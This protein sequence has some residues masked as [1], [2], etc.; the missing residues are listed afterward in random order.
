MKKL[1]GFILILTVVGS[2]FIGCKKTE[3]KTET[4][5]TEPKT[6]TETKTETTT[7]TPENDLADGV[8]YA[9]D[10]QFEDS[11]W[12]SVVTLEVADGKI[13]KADW[14]GF[15]ANAGKDKK[16]L[17]ADGEYGMVEKGKATAEWHEQAAAVEAFL[18]ETQ[19]VEKITLKDEDGHTD[20]VTGATMK[21]G[22]FVELVK[23]ALANGPVG[24]GKYVDGYYNVEADEAESSGWK[25]TASFTVINGNIVAANWNGVKEG[26]EKDKKTTSI[27]GEYG[28][29][30]KGKASAEWHVQAAAVEAYLIENQGF[31]GLSLNDEGKT[32]AITGA[33]ISVNGFVDLATKA[34]KLK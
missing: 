21:V 2:L 27:D 33:S 12:K 24:S 15:T 5:G 11:G 23:K 10:E 7:E 18:I 20:A 28:M 9:E 22:A 26:S 32:D 31:E 25:T 14:N 17:S 29:V 1:I 13:V 3:E 16:T 19:D 4:T 6:E 8:Y 34:L 30:E